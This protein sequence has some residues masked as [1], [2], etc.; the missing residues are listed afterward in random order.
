MSLGE[1]DNRVIVGYDGYNTLLYNPADGQ[2][3]YKGLGDS[4]R[5]FGAAGNVFISYIENLPE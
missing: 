1:N 4:T 5:D 3:V 2:T